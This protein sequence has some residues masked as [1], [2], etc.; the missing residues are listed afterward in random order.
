LRPAIT[1]NG[2][3]S[4]GLSPS[5]SSA[6]KKHHKPPL[7]LKAELSWHIAPKF[8]MSLTPRAALVLYAGTIALSNINQISTLKKDLYAGG[9]QY[10]A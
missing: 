2:W 4:N 1:L 3:D 7:R 10:F 5:G 9:S 8:F 6:T